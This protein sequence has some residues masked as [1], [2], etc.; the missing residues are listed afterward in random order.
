MLVFETLGLSHHDSAG[1]VQ[2][3]TA[4]LRVCSATGFVFGGLGFGVQGL[5]CRAYGLEFKV[6]RC[7]TTCT[8]PITRIIPH[9]PPPCSPCSRNLGFSFQC[10]GL[11]CGIAGRDVE[12]ARGREPPRPSPHPSS[13]ASLTLNYIPET[14]NPVPQTLNPKP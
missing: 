7:I 9:S 6:A 3:K 8:P 1:E 14:I 2:G 11:V 4:G 5:G 12:G 13:P 10:L